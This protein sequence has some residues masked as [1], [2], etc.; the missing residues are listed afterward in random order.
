M[1][2]NILS[3]LFKDYQ[4][5]KQNRDRA[6]PEIGLPNN[7]NENWRNSI[8]NINI[9]KTDDFKDKIISKF[10]DMKNISKKIFE[11]C[12]KQFEIN[13]ENFKII[14][15][16]Y[17]DSSIRNICKILE[18][19]EN[20][21]I[22][23]KYAKKNIFKNINKIIEIYDNIIKNI[24]DNFDLLNEYLKQKEII[25][26]KNPIEK[27]LN[28][29]YKNIVNI[30]LLNKFK[31]DEV[32]PL[33]IIKNRYFRYYLNYLNEEKKNPLIKTLT[34]QNNI[35]SQSNFIKQYHNN[36]KNMKIFKA[37]TNDLQIILNSFPKEQ[38]NY[39]LNK[40]EI[41]DF[42]FTAPFTDNRIMNDKL[43]KVEKVKFFK[44][45]L[46]NSIISK[47]I[48]FS[49]ESLISLSLEKISLTNI[50]WKNLLNYFYEN[51]K[52]LENIQY[53]SLARNLLSSI[54][55]E[56][57]IIDGI[58]VPQNTDKIFKNLKIFNLSKNDIYKFEM[59]YKTKL[60]QL[61][62]LD[63]SSNNIP[64]SLWMD[65][66]IK[67]ENDKLILFNDNIFITNSTEN[68]KN[69]IDYLNRQIPLLNC[70]LKYL[71]LRFAYDLEN[72]KELEKLILSPNTK[73]SLIRLD[74]SFC[75][76]TTDVVIN[77]L[78]NNFGLFS[79]KTMKLKYNNIKSDIFEKIECD[80]ILFNNLN[81]VD[82]SQNEISCKT[83]Q[84]HASLINF[85]KKNSNLEKIVLK[86]SLYY[87]NLINLISKEY[88]N[89]NQIANL[90]SSFGDNLKNN[91]RVF[92]F[93][94]ESHSTYL[95]EQFR[96]LFRFKS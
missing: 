59:D 24:E 10:N 68:N 9:Q 20:N 7:P 28:F 30:N 82:L 67:K 14:I 76:L 45:H 75:G 22:F 8:D 4:N 61:K 27:F 89:N 87:D 6:E 94:V 66:I 81:V 36:F 37:N 48:Q 38:N 33:N 26:N 80:E 70:D 46:N 2:E 25:N 73:I 78:K 95:E 77:F 11:K 91:N 79:L 72:Q 57:A 64:T 55:K 16:N 50:G 54:N 62:L 96:D 88:N 3:I 5:N 34:I 40:I 83:N 29:N 13:F 69:Y 32:D 49:G 21:E 15:S 85:I 86:N 56:M 74:L 44:G 52:I 47:V 84:E 51:K 43:N 31:F 42:D 35:S 19:P 39:N 12:T 71:N 17:L 60:P 58:N 41:N 53:L 1:K 18:K 93:E 63:L 23:L 90:Y 65:A 92:V